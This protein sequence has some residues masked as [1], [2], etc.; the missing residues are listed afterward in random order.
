[1][2]FADVVGQPAAKTGLL[3][4]W[5]KDVFPHALLLVG[6][7]GTGGLPLGLA[8]AQYIFC[9]HKTENDSCGSCPSCN[10]VSKLEHSDLH[11]AFPTIPPKAGT[12][13]MSRHFIK[14]F[15]EFTHQT[16]YGTTY[17]WLQYIKAENKQ[18][19]ITAEECRDI[20]EILNLKAYEG[21]RKVQLI[22]RPEYLGKEG[23][24]LLKLVEEP[25]KDTV[26]IFIA[27]QT[28]DILMTIRSRTQM[29]RLAPI[30]PTDIAT[31]LNLHE[32]VSEQQAYQIAHV[33]Q[34]SYSEALKLV[35]HLDNNLFPAVRELFNSLFTNNGV[36]LVKFAEEWSKAGREQQKN[37]LQYIVQ[38]M[39][40]CIRARYIPNLPIPLPEAEA[41]FVKKLAAT[42]VTF[43][44][45]TDIVKTLTDTAYYIERNAHA[46][47]QLLAMCIK[48][49]HHIQNKV[50][51]S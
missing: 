16:P 36:L 20:I 5:R 10:K 3:N 27:E 41:Q 34:G 19:N 31:A 26:I 46:K 4:M 48:M 32:K 49:Q 1:M 42:K 35:A 51:P 11:L 18:G 29:V 7:E 8:L 43:Q 39:E 24:I 33:S 12:K 38:L 44:G 22:W 45:F 25:P 2:K 30:A 13:A 37:F 23:N 50:V 28:E 47:S 9:E 17:D 6:P 14:E 15:K 40:Q 21:G